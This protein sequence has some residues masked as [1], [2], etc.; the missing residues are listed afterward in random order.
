MMGPLKAFRAVRALV[1]VTM[2]PTNLDEVFVLADLSE[3]SEQ[4]DKLIEAL[5]ADRRF[6]AALR[7]RPRLGAVDMRALRQMPEG[8]VGRAYASFMDVRGL[9]HEDLQMVDSQGDLGWVRNHLRET[10]DLWHVATGFH[11][12]VAG[13]LGL[14]AFYLSQFQ[15]PLPV[16]LLTVGFANTMLK[17]MDDVDRRMRAIV[18]G[19]LLGRRAGP[20][21]GMRWAERWEQPIDEF[22]A[23]LGLDLEGLEEELDRTAPRELLER[24]A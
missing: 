5:R 19:W 17:G 21:F 4:L 1:R 13:E 2:D 8:S 18:R 14:Q 10:H 20:L 9:Q 7:D 23:E 6:E 22:R 11:T 16:L 15:G 12:D 3:E 24:A